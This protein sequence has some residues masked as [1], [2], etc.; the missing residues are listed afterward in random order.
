ML[1]YP[2]LHRRRRARP[3]RSSALVALAVL[4]AAG[5]ESSGPDIGATLLAS[6]LGLAGNRRGSGASTAASDAPRTASALASP[7]QGTDPDARSLV[8]VSTAA[9]ASPPVD[10]TPVALDQQDERPAVH[11]VQEGQDR[12]RA[13]VATPGVAIDLTVPSTARIDSASAKGDPLAAAPPL[14]APPQPTPGPPDAAGLSAA[15]ILPAP[16]SPIIVTD[17]ATQARQWTVVRG[18][19]LRQTLENWARMASTEIVYQLPNDMAVEVDGSFDGTFYEALTWLLRGF[20]R[21]RPRPIAR[22]RS[23]A[24]L[25]QA[26][27]DD[28]GGGARS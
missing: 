16:A 10:A 28:L 4:T 6:N 11:G 8:P 7:A 1:T 9:I 13:T 2:P 20:D 21:A 17:P 26:S 5:C 12:D 19:T 15:P 24:V 18:S 3:L 25:I 27:K 22:K 23:N 14:S